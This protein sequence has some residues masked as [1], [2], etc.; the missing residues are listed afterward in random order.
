MSVSQGAVGM[1]L[2]QIT[3]YEFDASMPSVRN[4]KASRPM[5]SNTVS[6]P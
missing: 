5:Q 6:N 1:P 4:D 3:R 2:R